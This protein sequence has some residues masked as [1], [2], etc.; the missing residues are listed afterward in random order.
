MSGNN[1]NNVVVVQQPT[2]GANAAPTIPAAGTTHVVV[3]V[4]E[5]WFC[6]LYTRI[7]HE[8]QVLV[9]Q[10]KPE[11]D[12]LLA[13]LKTHVT[14]EVV[15]LKT[16]L[17]TE[18]KDLK[19]DVANVKDALP[20]IATQMEAGFEGQTKLS[21]AIK[22]A[23]AEVVRV[24]ESASEAAPAAESGQAVAPV[25]VVGGTS[26]ITAEAAATHQ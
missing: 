11:A 16:D 9:S 14:S 1:A 6:G 3:P 25:Q 8:V 23:F 2:S 18:L 21:T 5:S 10:A 19:G 12:A 17:S 4:H 26:D 22:D 7:K 20:T 15:R 13:E 24:F